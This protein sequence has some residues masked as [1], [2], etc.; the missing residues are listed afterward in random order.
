MKPVTLNRVKVALA[1]QSAPVSQPDAKSATIVPPSVAKKPSFLRFI[2]ELDQYVT[3]AEKTQTAMAGV[4][5]AISTQ[6]IYLE[7]LVSETEREQKIRQ[8]PA[9]ERKIVEQ[10]LADIISRTTTPTIIYTWEEIPAPF[11][12]DDRQ[13]QKRIDAEYKNA[14]DEHHQY[15]DE[16]KQR[17]VKDRSFTQLLYPKLIKANFPKEKI[18]KIV[19]TNQLFMVLS[20]VIL[21]KADTVN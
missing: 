19:P 6:R 15:F 11:V 3:A 13:I 9:E 16:I 2:D 4:K 20:D 18:Y 14:M 17:C 21:A 5:Q 10:R 1:N 12:A 7:F 8:M